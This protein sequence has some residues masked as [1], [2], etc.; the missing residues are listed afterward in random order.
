MSES[1]MVASP[2]VV[3]GAQRNSPHWCLQDHCRCRWLLFGFL[4]AARDLC[5]AGL[6][7]EDLRRRQGQAEDPAVHDVGEP[8][9]IEPDR[10]TVLA[11]I[12]APGILHDEAVRDITDDGKG[13]RRGTLSQREKVTGQ[14]FDRQIG[15]TKRGNRYADCRIRTGSPSTAIFATLPLT[16]SGH[17]GNLGSTESTKF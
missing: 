5:L 2:H 9:L 10:G 3:A 17:P 1:G 15:S 13:A 8:V 12:R 4:G 6:K 14:A 11:P 16:A 7:A